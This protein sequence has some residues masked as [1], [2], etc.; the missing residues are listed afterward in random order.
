MRP[1]TSC[2]RRKHRIS[3]TFSL[4]PSSTTTRSPA[5]A[6]AAKLR[7]ADSAALRSEGH[8][9]PALSTF[10]RRRLRRHERWLRSKPSMQS[11]GKLSRAEAGRWVSFRSGGS[12]PME[13]EP[14]LNPEPMPEQEGRYLMEV[15][16]GAGPFRRRM[17]PRPRPAPGNGG[18]ST[19]APARAPALEVLGQAP[20]CRGLLAA[21]GARGLRTR[22]R[23][24]ARCR[25]FAT[26]MARSLSS[27]AP[28]R[29]RRARRAG[30]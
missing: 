21:S 9:S 19:L 5:A 12:G 24:D 3:A 6:S 26:V 7:F 17:S 30:S 29:A 14:L 20:S 4:R 16:G 25:F 27:G 1:S 2:E 23:V 15:Q 22:Q 8:G 10:S 18:R 11:C 28:A 13:S